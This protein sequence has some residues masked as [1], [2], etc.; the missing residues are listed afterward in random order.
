[1][2]GTQGITTAKAL[3]IKSD[4]VITVSY[5]GG[6]AIQIAANGFHLLGGTSLTAVSITT[7]SGVTATVTYAI[8]G[9]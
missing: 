7:A 8:G 3:L 2:I 4:Q 5:N 6:T 9:D 1:V